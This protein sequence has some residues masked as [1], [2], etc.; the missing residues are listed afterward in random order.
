MTAE[1]GKCTQLLKQGSGFDEKPECTRREKV[2]ENEME[3]EKENENANVYK[4][5]AT[6][7][8]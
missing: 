7:S 4:I 6:H 3:K 8:K 1:N 5:A 2:N